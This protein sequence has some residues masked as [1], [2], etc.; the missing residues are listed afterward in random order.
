MLKKVKPVNIILGLLK[1]K[2]GFTLAKTKDYHPFQQSNKT[3]SKPDLSNCNFTKAT[4]INPN[5]GN[6]SVP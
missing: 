1:A 4:S 6:S 3:N 2:K 5:T